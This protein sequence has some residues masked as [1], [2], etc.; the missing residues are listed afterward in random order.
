[1]WGT[2]LAA[3]DTGLIKCSGQML[4]QMAPGRVMSS[5]LQSLAQLG[6]DSYCNAD[7][8]RS[9]EGAAQSQRALLGR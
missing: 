3:S 8:E 5:D 1:M 9:A 4:E 7:I 6:V 2:S